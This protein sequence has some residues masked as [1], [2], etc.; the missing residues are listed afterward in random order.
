MRSCLQEEKNRSGLQN[1]YGLSRWARRS[2]FLYRVCPS[3]I[4]VAWHPGKIALLWGIA[5]VILLML[6]SLYEDEKLTALVLWMVLSGPLFYAAWSGLVRAR[7]DRAPARNVGVPR[8]ASRPSRAGMIS[9]V[10]PPHDHPLHLTSA[11][12]KE[13]ITFTAR[14]ARRDREHPSPAEPDARR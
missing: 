6:L 5:V 2:C 11:M 14:R 7:G 13:A 3:R 1:R 12:S 8:G 10:M 4:L 9:I